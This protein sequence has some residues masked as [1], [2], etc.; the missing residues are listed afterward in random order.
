MTMSC[1][2]PS[3]SATPSSPVEQPTKRKNPALPKKR[4]LRRRKSGDEADSE[5]SNKQQSPKSCTSSS[6]LS[7]YENESES[8]E[9]I[10]QVLSNLSAKRFE[11]ECDAVTRASDAECLL[12]PTPLMLTQMAKIRQ[13]AIDRSMGL[14]PPISPFRKRNRSLSG[15]RTSFANRRKSMSKTPSPPPSSNKIH[16]KSAERK[17]PVK[18]AIS[19]CKLP[20]SA[21]SEV[22]LTTTQSQLFK[23]K[24]KKQSIENSLL[25]RRSARSHLGVHNSKKSPDKKTS[26]SQNIY[27]WFV[28]GTKSILRISQN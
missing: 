23:G 20:R 1:Q 25:L 14:P 26:I 5:T 4:V 7:E 10:E 27:N 17:S 2:P 16:S 13:R 28:N 8:E 3:A 11:E 24:N 19:R 15:C 6:Q 9:D 22:S 12:N 18:S 21:K